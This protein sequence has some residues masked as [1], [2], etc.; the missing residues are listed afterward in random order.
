MIISTSSWG[1][2]LMKPRD[3]NLL[4]PLTKKKERKKTHTNENSGMRGKTRN[5]VLVSW[6]KQQWQ[7]LTK[8]RRAVER[9]DIHRPDH[10]Q[11]DILIL[12]WACGSVALLLAF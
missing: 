3:S 12:D 2:Q 9:A 10:K 1:L 8:R 5:L 4:L 11:Y 6:E 7:W